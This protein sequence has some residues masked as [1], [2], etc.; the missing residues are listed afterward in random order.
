MPAT[1]IPTE[2]ANV[3]TG[4][5]RQPAREHHLAAEGRVVVEVGQEV[6]EIATA[7]G[8]SARRDGRRS[9]PGRG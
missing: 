7:A 3:A 8:A 2:A 4:H 1:S 5:E 9:A 6:V